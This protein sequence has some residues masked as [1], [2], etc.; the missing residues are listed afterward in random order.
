[1]AD[2]QIHGSYPF[3]RLEEDYQMDSPL[4]RKDRDVTSS[5][6]FHRN[7]DGWGVVVWFTEKKALHAS[8]STCERFTRWANS[9]R[10]ET[11]KYHS[12]QRAGSRV[13]RSPR[14]SQI[15]SG[16]SWR[17]D[18]C[19]SFLSSSCRKHLWKQHRGKR[20]ISAHS[21]MLQ[22]I[23]VGSYHIHNHKQ[24]AVNAYMLTFSS[25]PL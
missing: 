25:P 8:H 22:F 1:M 3:L 7:V 21:F 24:R 23:I 19:L 14:W 5:A 4:R 20:L 18:A 9:Q 6:I 16:Q 2:R 12:H 10:G 11:K 15:T 13:R 17:E